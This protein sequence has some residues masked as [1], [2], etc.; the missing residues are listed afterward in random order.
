MRKFIL[1]RIDCYLYYVAH[2]SNF[3]S[4]GH[5]IWESATPDINI[6]GKDDGWNKYLHR[7]YNYGRHIRRI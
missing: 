3:R 6:R 1:F 4:A 7:E 2:P 5:N